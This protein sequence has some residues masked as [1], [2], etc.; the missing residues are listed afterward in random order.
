MTARYRA[1]R[2]LVRCAFYSSIALL[3]LA[4]MSLDS[5]VLH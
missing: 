4:V 3:A 5:P 2:T 1:V